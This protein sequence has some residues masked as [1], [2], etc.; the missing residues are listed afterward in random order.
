M[1]SPRPARSRQMLDLAKCSIPARL[2][3]HSWA[4][5]GLGLAL[6][7]LLV[8]PSSQI[9]MGASQL[10]GLIGSYTGPH[11]D[12][13]Y[14]G[15]TLVSTPAA[16]FAPY[17]T[18][19]YK[20]T[21]IANSTGAGN[22]C[23]AS[24]KG[25][26]TATFNWNN[27][28]ITSALPP[29]YAVVSQTSTASWGGTPTNGATVT[30]TVD[31]GLNG[32]VVPGTNGASSTSTTYTVKSNPG[33]SF[34][35]SPACN[36]NV[37]FTGTDGTGYDAAV[38]GLATVTYTA[39]A[40]PISIV[41]QGQLVD[42]DGTLK[43][44][45]GQRLNATVNAP[46]TPTNYAWAAN[47]ATSP[48][49]FKT[50]DSTWPNSP[51]PTQFVPLAANDL[52]QSNFS[53][54]DVHN[55]DS[56]T[57]QCVITF[58]TPD[59][60]VNILSLTTQPVK[61]FKPTVTWTAGMAFGPIQNPGFFSGV[62]NGPFGAVEPWGPIQITVPNP[63]TG[64]TGCIAQIAKLDRSFANTKPDL[65][66]KLSVL[67][68]KGT[69]NMVKAPTGLDVGFP[70]PFGFIQNAD[71]SFTANNNNYTWQVANK[72]FASDKPFQSYTLSVQDGPGTYWYSSVAN[73][74][75]TTYVM[76]QPPSSGGQP[77]IN[78]PLQS[79]TWS[80]GATASLNNSVWSVLQGP[81]WT[82]AQPS[83]TD[84]YPSWTQEIPFGFTM[85]P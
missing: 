51:N 38:T 21:G 7:V 18:T 50:W 65:Y 35:I 22:T 68:S 14:S 42:V 58:K 33:Q 20:G 56:I 12:V 41:L 5:S 73:D 61:F 11:Y 67:D 79:L 64:G 13:T 30:G 82:S 34:Q 9:K 72:G 27:A 84:A 75:F 29:P 76:Y 80:W 1:Q 54:Y 71:G 4:L 47:G 53:F 16:S 48:N 83:N 60:A 8:L 59:N 17:S 10:H 23:N 36:P 81:Q 52:T 28:G 66:S 45:T 55:G 49:P 74:S 62:P 19:S 63:F 24:A 57:V 39:S 26:L 3:Q 37:T 6:L 2:T 46:Y 78:V 31:N 85:G 15:G 32:P 43:A 25:P 70:Y 69:S 77:T 40:A 44:L